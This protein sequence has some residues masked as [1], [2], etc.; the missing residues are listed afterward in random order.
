[1]S[2]HYPRI[3]LRA[4][5]PEGERLIIREVVALVLYLPFDHQQLAAAVE[6]AMDTYL[7]AVGEG[8]E[9]I[10]SWRDGE[11]GEVSPLNAEQW[12]LIRLMLREKSPYRYLDQCDDERYA[13]HHL[14][15]Q[16]EVSFELLGGSSGTSGYGFSYWARLPWSTPRGGDVSRIEFSWPTEYL[17]QHG[18][19]RMR[20]MVLELASLLPFVS[21]H[22][23]LALEL[24]GTFMP[25]MSELREEVFRYPGMDVPSGTT[26]IGTRVDGVHWLN[27]LAQPV[28]GALGG[29]EGLR[30]RLHSAETTV[31][32]LDGERAVVTLGP[33]PEAGDLTQGRDLPA[34]RELARVLEPW[35]DDF[36]NIYRWRGYTPEETR[37]WWRRFLSP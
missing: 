26:M 21:G 9:T 29:V 33:W 10:S 2:E 28:L 27:F 14:K 30:S 11:I 12:E 37:R 5:G 31:Q 36:T 24:P 23:G 6:H 15:Q 19:G 20:E 32:Q 35:L 22:A 16:C 13:N 7:Q 8:P 34:Y 18:P 4:S 1:M 17:E 25:L 3:R